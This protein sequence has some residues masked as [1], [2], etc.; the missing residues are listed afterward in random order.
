[1]EQINTNQN[2]ILI[3]YIVRQKVHIKKDNIK[4]HRHKPIFNPVIQTEYHT[5]R[6]I[7][8]VTKKMRINCKKKTFDQYV[9]MLKENNLRI[10]SSVIDYIGM[11]RMNQQTKMTAIKT[12]LRK[13][14]AMKERQ[15]MLTL[16]S[17]TRK[18]HNK[19]TLNLQCL[20]TKK[21]VKAGAI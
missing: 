17:T 9:A 19:H 12:A 11:V 8:E 3:L 15:R 6:R 5:K 1:M 18:S 13:S 21:Q 20:E 10:P 7:E 2:F 14:T 4:G 16:T